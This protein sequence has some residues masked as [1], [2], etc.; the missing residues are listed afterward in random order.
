M[1]LE[2][3]EGAVLWADAAFDITDEANR[4]M[5]AGEAGK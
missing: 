4:R 1:I 5:D 2:K 3:N